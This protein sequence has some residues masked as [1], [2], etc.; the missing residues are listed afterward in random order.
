MVRKTGCLERYPD[1]D[2][3]HLNSFEDRGY[4]RV[5]VVFGI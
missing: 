5:L 3:L 1:T 2:L 4:W